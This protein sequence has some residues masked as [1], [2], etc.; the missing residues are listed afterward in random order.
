MLLAMDPPRHNDYRRPMVKR[1]V[2]KVME[3]LEDR[4]RAITR[5]ILVDAREK[6]DVDFVA[7]RDLRRC[8]RR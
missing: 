1:F 8:R 5:E 7:R 2:P 4:I 6:G 3:E